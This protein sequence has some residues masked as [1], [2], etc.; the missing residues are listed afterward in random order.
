VE[1]DIFEGRISIVGV[2]VPTAGPNVDFHVAGFGRTVA[3]LNDSAAKVGSAFYAPKT[4]MQH[5]EGLTIASL[6]VVAEQ[7]LVLPNG[8]EQVFGRGLDVLAQNR[9]RAALRAEPRI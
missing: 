7:P 3:K 4:G 9:H 1:N 2:R 5:S 6:Q 8:L